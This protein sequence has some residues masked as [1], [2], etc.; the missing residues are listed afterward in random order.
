MKLLTLTLA[1]TLTAC[2]SDSDPGMTDSQ[3]Q[4]AVTI[5]E[6]AEGLPDFRSWQIIPKAKDSCFQVSPENVSCMTEFT[7]DVILKNCSDATFK[8]ISK[9]NGYMYVQ[10]LEHVFIRQGEYHRLEFEGQ[11]EIFNITDQLADE[12]Y[13]VYRCFGPNSDIIKL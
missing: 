11:A 13:H 2:G 6:T 1:L 5:P 7:M 8:F 3:K 9:K 4:N 12:Q 10:T